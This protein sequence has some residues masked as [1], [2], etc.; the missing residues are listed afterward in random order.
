MPGRRRLWP[1]RSLLRLRPANLG[2]TLPRPAGPPSP[3]QGFR[4]PRP[5]SFHPWPH[6]WRRPVPHG[7]TGC[8]CLSRHP[9]RCL[10]VHRSRPAACR[11]P[12]L[13]P[14]WRR[15]AWPQT[16]WEQISRERPSHRDDW[17]WAA[18]TR[19]RPFRTLH[20]FPPRSPLPPCRLPPPCLR[21]RGRSRPRRSWCRC[22]RRRTCPPSFRSL[23][24]PRRS[25]Q[26][27]R[28]VRPTGRPLPPTSR[29]PSPRRCRGRSCPGCPGRRC[30]DRRG[31]PI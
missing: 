3:G 12:S 7:A 24:S 23:R 20:P 30:P 10:E 9:A 14:P 28:R 15:T 27:F 6:G 29:C 18:W 26:G 2:L 16:V 8:R 11:S 19:R 31:W 13:R 21:C 1:G 4:P 5:R 17:T 22:G 25:V